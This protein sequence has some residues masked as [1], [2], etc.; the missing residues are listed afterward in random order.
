M[1]LWV[2]CPNCGPVLAFTPQ[3]RASFKLSLTCQCGVTAV[4][5]EA[6][7]TK[8]EQRRNPKKDESSC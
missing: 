5:K 7:F 4:H 8:N 3:G 2:T 1:T 6:L